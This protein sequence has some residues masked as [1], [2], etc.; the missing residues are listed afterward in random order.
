MVVPQVRE[1]AV[2]VHLLNTGVNQEESTQSRVDLSI[3]IPVLNEE[4]GIRVCLHHLYQL[5]EQY[6]QYVFETIVVDGGSHDATVACASSMAD[7]VIVSDK[8][9][10][11]QMNAGAQQA[12]GRYLLFLHSDTQF[13]LP[14]M[15]SPVVNTS[16]HLFPFLDKPVAERA[17]WGFYPVCLSGDPG[18]LRVVETMMNVRSRLTSVATGDQCIFV[19][20]ALYAEQSGFSHIP[21]MEDVEFTK[22]LRKL[23]TPYI[24]SVKVTTDSRRWEK[25]GVIKTI[26]LMWYLRALYFFGVNPTTLARYYYR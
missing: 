5:S 7:L 13:P 20:S 6:P 4:E 21:L 24:P 16:Q 25:H 10:A 18:L 19:S 22:R 17:F 11:K 8:G 14:S 9:R 2:A 23:H 15:S 1:V 3:I 26:I 12:T